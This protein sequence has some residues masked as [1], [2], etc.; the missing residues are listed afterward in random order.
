MKKSVELDTPESDDEIKK[1]IIEL[2]SQYQRAVKMNDA[3]IMDRILADDFILVTGRGKVYSKSDLLKEARNGKTVYEHQEDTN[4]TVRVWGDT[5]VI[6]GLLWEKGV[7]N[8]KAFDKKLWFSD[9]YKRTSHGWKYV[10]A[11]ASIPLPDSP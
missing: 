10:F 6:T 9:V 11:Q 2:D 4:Q 5:A 1:H 8:G 7:S 3:A